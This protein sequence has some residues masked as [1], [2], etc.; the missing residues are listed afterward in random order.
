MLVVSERQTAYERAVGHGVPKA[1]VSRLLARQG[2][3]KLVPRAVIPAPLR[4][5]SPGRN[6]TSRFADCTFK[7][8]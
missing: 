4:G 2:W 7:W 3:R 1:T 8:S 6:L 5:W